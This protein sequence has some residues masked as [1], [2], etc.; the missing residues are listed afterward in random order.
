[1]LALPAAG[2]QLGKTVLAPAIG[3]SMGNAVAQLARA[4]DARHAVSTTTSLA[5]SAEALRYLV[6]AVRSDGYFSRYSS[7]VDRVHDW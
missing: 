4:L 7:H 1:M 3:G 5:K 6:E 2:F